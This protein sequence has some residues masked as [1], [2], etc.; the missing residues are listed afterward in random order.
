MPGP[1]FTDKVDLGYLPTYL[2]LA[3]QIG[4]EGR[5]CE[6]GVH[7]G[8]SLDMWRVLFPAGLVVGVDHDPAARWP[9]G[10][11]RIVAAQDDPALP[12]RLAAVSPRFD[13]VVDDASHDGALTRATWEL[14]WPLVAPGGWYVVEDWQVG[15]DDWPLFDASMLALARSLLAELGQGGGEVAEIT[16]RHGMIVLERRSDLVK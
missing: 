15:F 10:T 6:V 1:F 8:H 4:I 12:R 3:G 14:L 9:D 7:R 13:L 11:H 5:V 2:R 16:Y